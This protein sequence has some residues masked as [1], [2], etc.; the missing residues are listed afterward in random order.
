MRF[1]WDIHFAADKD[2]LKAGVLNTGTHRVA[3]LSD[4]LFDSR[5]VAEQMVACHGFEPTGA[6]LIDFPL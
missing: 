6:D 2:A 1:V 3:V 4:D 5:L